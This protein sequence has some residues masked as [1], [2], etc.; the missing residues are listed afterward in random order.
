MAAAPDGADL[1]LNSPE[2]LATLFEGRF[3]KC[4]AADIPRLPGAI[5]TPSRNW[6]A[7]HQLKQ[8]RNRARL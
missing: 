4:K 6:F 3:Q 1:K 2:S 7:F 8:G 5:A